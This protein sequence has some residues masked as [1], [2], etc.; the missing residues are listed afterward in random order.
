MSLRWK[1]KNGTVHVA[2]EVMI[3]SEHLIGKWNFKVAAEVEITTIS[4][5]MGFTEIANEHDHA[6]FI[7]M[8]EEGM[9]IGGVTSEDDGHS[10]TISLATATDEENNHKHRFFIPEVDTD[11][12]S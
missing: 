5:G 1:F 12:E 11:D 9:I 8:D 3:I 10:H 4:Q 7:E 2:Q 6:F